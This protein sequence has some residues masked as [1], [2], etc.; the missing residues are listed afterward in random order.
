MG[1]FILRSAREAT[2]TSLKTNVARMPRH[3]RD[4]YLSRFYPGTTPDRV[5]E[6]TVLESYT[7]NDDHIDL[8][9]NKGLYAEALNKVR[10]IYELPIKLPIL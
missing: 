7:G 2:L 4:N 6:A 9:L 5:S 10:S 3:T 1:D 8:L